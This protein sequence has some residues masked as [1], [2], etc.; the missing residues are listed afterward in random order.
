[1]TP[2]P[3]SRKSPVHEQRAHLLAQIQRIRTRL[4]ALV[5]A[6]RQL[7][8]RLVLLN[9]VCPDCGGGLAMAR[10]GSCRC[11]ACDKQMDPTVTFQRCPDCE[12][13]LELRISRYRCR[14]CHRDV[15]SQFLFDGKVFDAEYFQQKM[16]EARQ[17]RRQQ[18]TERAERAVVERSP[19]VVPGPA[20]PG[21]VPGLTEALNSL[22]LDAA[23][24]TVE[25]AKAQFDLHRCEQHVLANLA[26]GEA[27]PFDDLPGLD[28]G[29]RLERVWLF[30]AVVFLMHSGSLTAWQDGTTLWVMKHEADGKRQ[31]VPADA[32]APDHQARALG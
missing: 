1:M 17:R 23:P 16:A 27:V 31:G 30:I 11:L 20:D 5:E 25:R 29:D 19:R 12:G 10:E 14:R 13:E 32:Q 9:H 28:E 6:V 18:K 8:Y 4:D 2:T 26:A 22:T 15:A 7:F 21:A 3:A 24:E